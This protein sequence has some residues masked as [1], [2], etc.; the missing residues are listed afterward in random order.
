MTQEEKAR[1]YDEAKARI[2]KAFNDNRCTIGFM[3]E[4]F[5]ELKG[6]E[7]E[8][9][10]KALIKYYSFNKD[11]GSHALDN[12]TPKQIVDWLEKQGEQKP[13]EWTAE[14]EEELK[15]ALITL[16]KAGRYSSAK[17]LKNVC[18][19]PQTM[20]RSAWRNEEDENRINRLIAYFEGKESFTAEDD[21]VYANW[22]K[23]LK[24]KV[25]PQPKQEWSEDDDKNLEKTIWCVEKVGKLIFAKTDKLVSWLK[26][27]KE[28][29]QPQPKQEW[30]EEDRDYYDAIIAKLEVTQEDALLTDSQMEFLKSLKE[31]YFWKPTDEQIEAIRL[32]R[33]FV[34]DDFSDNP[35]LSEILKDL[36]N[37]LKAL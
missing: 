33:A 6:S 3:N 21:I 2:S 1:A 14:D 13:V 32:A 22:L 4:I 10:R 25:K 15:I 36:Q 24:N 30:S 28:K 5:P 31:R 12:I 20:Q 26:S 16:E 23:S 8:R 27:L 37:Q 35:T 29:L 17:W 11:G 18:L 9:I 34:T 19:V 7:D